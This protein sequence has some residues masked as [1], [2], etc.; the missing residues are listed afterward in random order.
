MPYFCIIAL[1]HNIRPGPS[2][3]KG[4]QLVGPGLGF[5]P[6]FGFLLDG[7]YAFDHPDLG[8]IPF[9]AHDGRAGIILAYLLYLG[10]ILK[11]SGRHLQRLLEA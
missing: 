2:G 9:V 3:L 8:G 1:S 11:G 6:L 7:D 10:T 4:H 5:G